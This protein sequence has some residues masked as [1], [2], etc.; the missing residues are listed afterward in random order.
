[1]TGKCICGGGSLMDVD[2]EGRFLVTSKAVLLFE[3]SDETREE[4]NPIGA[5]RINFCPVC[6]RN[7]REER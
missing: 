6:G 3:T 7:L 4:D 2:N 1:M 5:A